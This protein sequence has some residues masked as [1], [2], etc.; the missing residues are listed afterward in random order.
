VQLLK[1]GLFYFAIAFGS[2]FALGTIRTLWVVP[3]VGARK[4]ELAEM[5]MMLGVMIVAA[6]W[7][8]LLLAVPPVVAARLGMGGIA[9]TLMLAAEFGLVR[10]VRGLSLN[11]YF[12]N[13]DRM[14]GAAYYALLVVFAI[15]P[16]FVGKR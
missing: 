10:W 16:L 12:A 13:R 6:R 1:A 3:R 7:V 11:E 9:L 2:G 5:P 14:A 4:A 15:M 8:V